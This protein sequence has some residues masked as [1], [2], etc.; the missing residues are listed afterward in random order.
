MNSLHGETLQKDILK[1]YQCKSEMWTQTEYGERVLDYQ[2]IN[3][4]IYIVKMKYD[5]GLEDEIKKA[6][7][8]LYN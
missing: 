7:T 4:G 2:K 6:N 8:L 1:S 3:H 5:E